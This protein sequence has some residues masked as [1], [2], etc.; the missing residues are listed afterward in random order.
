[1]SDKQLMF[2]QM[3]EH[4][5]TDE[6]PSEYFNAI[7]DNLF[8]SVFP[9]TMLSKLKNT[10]QSMQHHPEGSV[11][12][13][14]MLVIDEAA[15]V[16][17]NSKSPHAFMWAALL[18]DIGKA[19]TTRMKKDRIISYDHDK[20][21]AEKARQ[22]LLEFIEDEHFIEQ[23]ANL[24]RWHMQILFV[25]RSMPFADIETMKN[26]TD[27]EEIAL[28]GLCDRMGRHGADRKSEE[29]NIRMFLQKCLM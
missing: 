24:V 16:K 28:L 26:Q 10:P 18:H 17:M 13:H 12:N 21:G 23:V 20:V 29:G 11:W 3:N 7:Q 9:F 5:L 6:Q 27:I 8:F 22:F 4:L 14:T 1:M 25:V 2:K 15:K 19:Y